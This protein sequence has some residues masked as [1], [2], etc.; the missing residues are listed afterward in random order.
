M[1]ARGNVHPHLHP[2][3]PPAYPPPHP[4]LA[5]SAFP[6]SYIQLLDRLAERHEPQL[7]QLLGSSY[8]ARAAREED[9]ELLLRFWAVK[10][11]RWGF[12]AAVRA[13]AGRGWDGD[14]VELARGGEGVGGGS[15]LLW[16]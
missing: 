7:Q 15:P 12:G 14:G 10:N 9:R 16:C 3:L 13:G 4:H 2:C 1:L 6:G 5:R 8:A 11:K